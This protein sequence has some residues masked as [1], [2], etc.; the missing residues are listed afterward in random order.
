MID[1]DNSQNYKLFLNILIIRFNRNVGKNEEGYL[2]KFGFREA[3]FA[4]PIIVLVF[5][6]KS[7]KP[8]SK[9]PIGR[10]KMRWKDDVLEDVRSMDVSNWKIVAQ[11]RDSW[12]KVVERARTL[13][14]L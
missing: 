3:I 9:R 14:R 10:P 7:W 2:R 12:K 4:F 11:N 1:Q 8:M 6:I 13:H 5:F